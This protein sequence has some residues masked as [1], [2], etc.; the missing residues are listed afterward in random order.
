M[1]LFV[2][3]LNANAIVMINLEEQIIILYALHRCGG[4]GRKAR[5]IHYITE[6]KLLKPREGDTDMRQKRETKL[7]ND[8]A[9]AR[10]DLKER[11]WL[12]MPQH[13]FWQITESGRHELFQVARAVSKNVLSE[14]NFRRYYTSSLSEEYFHRFN[15][16]LIHELRE[17]ARTVP[18]PT[19]AA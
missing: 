8:L 4:K 18:E 7:E 10:E 12:S 13:G 19:D 6:N 9:W 16:K 15:E 17:L 1:S 3:R 2:R 5:I 14:G 11:G